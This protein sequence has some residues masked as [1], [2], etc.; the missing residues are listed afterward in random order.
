MKIIKLTE[1]KLKYVDDG[2]KKSVNFNECHI[3]WKEYI[4]RSKSANSS[5]LRTDRIIGQRDITANRIYIEF[6][7]KPFTRIFFDD[8]DE[9][10]DLV[11]KLQR[12]NWH[13]ID[14]S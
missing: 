6:F 9:Y 14:L 1:S 7:T 2:V 10:R 11:Q 12:M 5:N 13:T 3:N 8:A 4:E